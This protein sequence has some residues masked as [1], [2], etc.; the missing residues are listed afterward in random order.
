MYQ[1]QRDAVVIGRASPYAR[2]G[3]QA[4]QV[5][6][7]QSDPVKL[8]ALETLLRTIAEKAQGMTT[9][10]ILAL[11]AAFLAASSSSSS[12]P[13]RAV[14]RPPSA[15][16]G[17][18]SSAT[19]TLHHASS[20]PEEL[21]QP[22]AV[23]PALE[24]VGGD[25]HTVKI[26]AKTNV[27]SIAG[28]LSKSLRT[29]EMI[30]ATAYGSDGANHGMKALSIAR[31]YL[32][33]EGLDLSATVAEVQPDPTITGPYR[34]FAFIVV[35]I[36]VP[37]KVGEP[38]CEAG[39]GR[40]DPLP[41]V[42][43]PEGFQTDMKVSGTGNAQSLAG[44]IAK[45]LREDREVVVTAIGPAS[46]S[47]CVEAMSLAR[48]HVQGDGL[49]LAFYPGFEHIV[50]QGTGPGAGEQRCCVRIHVWPEAAQVADA[51]GGWAMCAAT[52]GLQHTP[53]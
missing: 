35:R 47:K 4:Q 49:Q 7:T 28:A 14:A 39:V 31:C 45:C 18:T 5:P 1:L 36:Q 32:A 34:C 10:D 12:S 17:Q 25:L 41:R 11:N 40:T 38:L 19:V 24:E 51:G 43:R 13:P 30:V 16:V 8:A 44:A 42:V 53:Q 29:H 2:H 26:S 37:A 33:A 6:A 52:G 20:M 48:G 9:Q 50:M 21:S 27:K 3:G 46:V 22:G 23:L 15:V